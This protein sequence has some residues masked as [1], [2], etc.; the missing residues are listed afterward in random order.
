M[1][2]LHQV[3]LQVG[4]IRFDTN[5]RPYYTSRDSQRFK[6]LMEDNESMKGERKPKGL[7][8]KLRTER[9]LSELQQTQK[10]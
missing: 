3:D 9:L 7:F 4:K 6:N 5:L 2:R 10:A 1:K 8:K